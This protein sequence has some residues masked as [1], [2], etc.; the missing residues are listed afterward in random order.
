MNKAINL[1]VRFFLTSVMWGGILFILYD[2]LRIIRRIIKHCEVIIAIQDIL[3]WMISSVLIF[4]MMYQMNNGI[5]R[6][7]SVLGIT[8]GMILY[9]YL[10]SDWVV[11]GISYLL[12]TLIGW[13]KKLILFL[14]KPF[15]FVFRIMKKG[16]N[17]VKV[18]IKSLKNSLLN[19][20]QIFHKK[21]KIKKEAKKKEKEEQKQKDLQLKQ[22]K[23]QQKQKQKE[24]EKQILKQKLEQKKKEQLKEKLQEQQKRELKRKAKEQSDNSN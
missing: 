19:R 24:K 15:R 18:K 5:I 7:F 11:D 10:L 14:M 9:K 13:I 1:E 8:I 20:L 12:N 3:Y 22:Q 23:Q 2:A 17:K 6:G 16:V 21:V 4:R